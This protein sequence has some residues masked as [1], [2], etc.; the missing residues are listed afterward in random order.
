MNDKLVAF[1]KPRARKRKC[2]I[3]GRPPPPSKQGAPTEPFCSKRCADEDMRRWLG[4]E[5]RIA[6]S[7]PPD[8]DTENGDSEAGKG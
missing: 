2:P 5:Y 7:E 3:C 1:P 6:T 8:F 4:G